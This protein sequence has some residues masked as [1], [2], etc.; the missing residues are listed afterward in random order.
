MDTSG[1]DLQKLC[2]VAKSNTELHRK[3]RQRLENVDT[4]VTNN[5]D[6]IL[7][8]DEVEQRAALNYL[9]ASHNAT[10]ELVEQFLNETSYNGEWFV[11]KHRKGLDHDIPYVPLDLQ[12]SSVGIES[13]LSP[14]SHDQC[15][16]GVTALHLAVY[17][18]SLH[19][20]KIAKLLLS[21]KN[22]SEESSNV[23]NKEARK[24]S[25]ASIPMRCGSCPLHI[26]TGQNL[27]IKEE[28]LK[29]LLHSDPCVAFR[30]DVNG[31]NP[32]SLLWKNTLVSKNDAYN[33][34][35]IVF[36]PLKSVITTTMQLI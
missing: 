24:V 13:A 25:I 31:D 26:L 12:S 2:R 21:W 30:D 17:Q 11:E 34:V 10:K 28:V 20:N 14:P 7:G 18:N 19:A 32:I 16:N 5:F 9:L 1:R 33:V 36:C 15:L 6:S 4:K 23:S 29:T 3:I 27:T 35:C 22:T 8:C